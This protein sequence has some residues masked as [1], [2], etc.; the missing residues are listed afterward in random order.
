VFLS[1]HLPEMAMHVR[2]KDRKD[3]ELEI[4]QYGVVGIMEEQRCKYI[5]Y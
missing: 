1:L 5:H 4:V 3:Y 2:G